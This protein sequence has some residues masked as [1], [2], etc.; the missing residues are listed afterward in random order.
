[1][2]KSRPLE[3]MRNVMKL[4]FSMW[5]AGRLTL[6]LAAVPLL[7]T[8]GPVWASLQPRH[9]SGTVV[10]STAAAAGDYRTHS[11]HI[12]VCGAQGFQ[13]TVPFVDFNVGSVRLATT[14]PVVVQTGDWAD[15]PGLP[16]SLLTGATG[17]VGPNGEQGFRLR[18]FDQHGVATD[19]A[20]DVDCYALHYHASIPFTD[21]ARAAGIATVATDSRGFASVKF[22]RALA[23]APVSVIA[24]GSSPYV[25]AGLPV[26]LV[27]GGYSARG[28]T[29]RALDQHGT[30]IAKS[31]ISLH[32]W[33]TGQAETLDTRAGATTVTPNSDGIA[34]IPWTMFPQGY[35][36]EAAVLTGVGP[37]FGPNMPVNLLSYAGGGNGVQVRVLNQAGEPV[38]TPVRIAYYATMAGVTSL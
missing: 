34:F 19:N 13:S 5:V 8:G 20:T 28:F 38:T 23:A 11:Q 25:G 36:P 35:S 27:T 4:N 18:V 7:G 14:T 1:M 21:A 6:A 26:N 15:G 2:R 16:V 30:P 12:A 24:T 9:D 31:V 3:E 29:V 17:D 32:Y 33:A 22:A 10:S 37:S